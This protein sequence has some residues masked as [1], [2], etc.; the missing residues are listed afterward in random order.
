MLNKRRRLLNAGTA[1]ITVNIPSRAA[2]TLTYRVITFAANPARR[3][4]A[5]IYVTAAAVIIIFKRGRLALIIINNIYR[6]RVT[7]LL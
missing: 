1:Y 5:I 2:A 6:P 7:S 4:L 3:R